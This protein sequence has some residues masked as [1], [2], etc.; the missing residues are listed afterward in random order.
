MERAKAREALRKQVEEFESGRRAAKTWS[1]SARRML[2]PTG[3]FMGW[4]PGRHV[5]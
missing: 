3:L 1:D 4:S 5:R 2:S